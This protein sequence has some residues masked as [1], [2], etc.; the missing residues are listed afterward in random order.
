[1]ID[2]MSERDEFAQPPPVATKAAQPEPRMTFLAWFRS[3][4]RKEHHVTPMSRYA[5]TE[6]WLTA[7]EWQQR[8]AKY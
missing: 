8:F 6:G 5:S 1:M 2:E 7:A 4:G 3:T